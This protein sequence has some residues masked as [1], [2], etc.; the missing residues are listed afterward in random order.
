MNKQLNKL[1]GCEQT[2]KWAQR[3]YKQIDEWN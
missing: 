2:I 1:R 3:K